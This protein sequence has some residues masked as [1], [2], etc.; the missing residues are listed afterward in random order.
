M[1]ALRTYLWW[2]KRAKKNLH[3]ITYMMK[4]PKWFY[5]INQYNETTT[6][7]TKICLGVCYPYCYKFW[8]NSRYEMYVLGI[9]PTNLLFFDFVLFC[10]LLHSVLRSQFSHLTETLSA[11]TAYELLL[12]WHMRQTIHAIENWRLTK[13]EKRT[14]NQKTNSFT[15]KIYHQAKPSLNQTNSKSIFFSVFTIQA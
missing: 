2:S 13:T 3:C 9:S 6:T 7:T 1:N 11:R 8:Y 10:F 12:I 5:Y 4:N 14:K 15:K